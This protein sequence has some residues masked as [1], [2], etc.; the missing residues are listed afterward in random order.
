MKKLFC[1]FLIVL[2]MSFVMAEDWQFKSG[3]FI[4]PD[5]SFSTA[6]E[7]KPFCNYINFRLEITGTP[8]DSIA[9]DTMKIYIQTKYSAR[10]DETWHDLLTL[11]EDITDTATIDCCLSI[12]SLN[13]GIYKLGQFIRAKFIMSDTITA[14][15]TYTSNP[16]GYRLYVGYH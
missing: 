14:A 6:M 11:T 15:A 2:A 7:I 4:A 3:E 12:D 5:T 13:T 1:I 10:G 16:W 9:A 8:V